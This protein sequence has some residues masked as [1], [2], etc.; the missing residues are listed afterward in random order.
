[1][2]TAR[3]DVVHRYA[4]AFFDLAREQDVLGPLEADLTSLQS[5]LSESED[6]RRLAVSPVFD[7]DAKLAGFSAVLDRL[8][9]HE[10]TRNFIK[11]LARNRRLSDVAAIISAFQE[12]AA[13]HR[14]EVAA[15]AVVARALSDDQSKALRNQI[16][17]SIG[18]SVNLS[19]RVDPT[20]LGGLVVK[21]GS[22]MIDSSLRTKLNRL[23]QTLKEA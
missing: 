11:L 2:A 4:V 17:S 3:S 1:M 10:L 6:L 15:E 16:E 9:A 23:Q 21:V 7:T 12:F 8:D 20:L 22:R 19:T 14:G 13:D 5:A 18:K